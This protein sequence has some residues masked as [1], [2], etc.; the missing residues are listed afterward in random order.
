MA[1]TKVDSVQ[2]EILRDC[3]GNAPG[4]STYRHFKKGFKGRVK[5]MYLS[6]LAKDKDY[7]VEDSKG[8]KE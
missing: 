8:A 3:T 6:N 2:V 1:Q 7:K 5:S 4:G